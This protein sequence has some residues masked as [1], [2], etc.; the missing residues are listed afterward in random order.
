M[1]RLPP[2]A[3]PLFVGLLAILFAVFR[4]I[5]GCYRMLCKV[6]GLEPKRS[7]WDGWP[8]WAELCINILF[9]GV[10]VAL[11]YGAWTASGALYNGFIAISILGVVVIFVF[12]VI[13]A[14]D[15]LSGNARRRL[16]EIRERREVERAALIRAMGQP[17]YCGVMEFHLPTPKRPL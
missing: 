12:F 14:Y 16:D 1:A 10:L 2:E 17:E 5:G 9:F 4:G 7:I 13:S 8:A 3:A 6:L 11:A 15:D